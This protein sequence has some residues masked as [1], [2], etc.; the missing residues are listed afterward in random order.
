MVDIIM[1]NKAPTYQGVSRVCE[2]RNVSDPKSTQGA[3]SRNTT[4]FD[5]G[6]SDG[7]SPESMGVN[8]VVSVC[9]VQH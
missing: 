7:K 4:L 3:L 6:T 1:H 5:I 2:Q 8:H 9:Q